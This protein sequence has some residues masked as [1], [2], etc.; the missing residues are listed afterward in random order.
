[1]SKCKECGRCHT[2]DG[3]F[4]PHCGARNWDVQE[5]L[6]MIAPPRNTPPQPR[7]MTKTRVI[8]SSMRDRLKSWF[9]S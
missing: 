9:S 6:V 5:V 8:A 7:D 4:C 2:G 3:L 1:M